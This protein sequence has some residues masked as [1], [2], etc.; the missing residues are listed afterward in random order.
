MLNV[1]QL[2]HRTAGDGC[3]HSQLA[4]DESDRALLLAART[5]IRDHL[6]KGVAALTKQNL[7]PAKAVTPRF[8][9]QGSFAYGTLNDPAQQP[10]QEIDLDDGTYLPLSLMRGAAPSDASDVF[11]R[12]VDGL[13][14]ELA[15]KRGWQVDKSRPTCVRVHINRRA[16]IDVPLYAIPDAEYQT[17]VEKSLSRGYSTLDA[18]FR[19]AGY[20]DWTTLDSDSVWLAVR[21]GKWIRSDPRKVHAWVTRQARLFGA[22]FIRICKYLKAWRDEQWRTGG[23]SSIL[24]M[25]CASQALLAWGGARDD[26]ALASVA[27]DLVQQLAGGVCNPDVDATAELNDL[28]EEERSDACSKAQALSSAI[29]FAMDVAQDAPGAIARLR[30][31]LGDRVPDRPDWVQA[32]TPASVVRAVPATVVAVPAVKRAHSA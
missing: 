6:R 24:L 20:M 17:L 15:V 12:I 30:G 22:Q 13:L 31:V 32:V 10:P 11:F 25:V 8:F 3:F 2:L 27:K 9:T 1:T 26:K 29:E 14:E 19:E 7:G 5:L 21:G 4:I 28:S 18:A 16:H 23:P